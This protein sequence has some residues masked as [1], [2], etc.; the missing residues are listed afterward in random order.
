[1]SNVYLNDLRGSYKPVSD[2]LGDAIFSFFEKFKWI[3]TLWLC[4]RRYSVL[5]GSGWFRRSWRRPCGPQRLLTQLIGN[6]LVARQKPV[7]K[8]QFDNVG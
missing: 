1:M 4:Q 3:Q 6:G 7:I 2:P 8:I 5:F